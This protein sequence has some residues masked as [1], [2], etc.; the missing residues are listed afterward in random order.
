[1]E[2]SEVKKVLSELLSCQLAAMLNTF[3]KNGFRTV[4]GEAM[5]TGRWDRRVHVDFFRGTNQNQYWVQRSA[6]AE[7]PLVL[8][9]FDSPASRS[10]LA[11]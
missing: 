7:E 10:P 9:N 1:M 11:K 2:L 8:T 3:H 6:Q 4:F 5:G